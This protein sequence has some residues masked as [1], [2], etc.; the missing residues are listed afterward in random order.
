LR[1]RR[2]RRG[3]PVLHRHRDE[4]AVVAVRIPELPGLGDADR[5]ALDVLALERG[6]DQVLEL[7]AVPAVEGAGASGQLLEPRAVAAAEQAG[8]VDHRT[9]QGRDGHLG[10]GGAGGE[11][12]DE[13]ERAHRAA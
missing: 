1:A 10:A 12:D 6:N 3:A 9:A 13:G 7:R 11:Y 8:R 5:V 2:A 4:D